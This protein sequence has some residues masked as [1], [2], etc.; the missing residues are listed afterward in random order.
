MGGGMRQAGFLAA[1]GLYALKHH[2][3]RLSVDHERAKLISEQLKQYN[4]VEE[5]MPVETNII[6]ARLKKEKDVNSLCAELTA[7]G[8]GISNIGNNSFR[9]VFH[10]NQQN[11]DIERLLE[12]LKEVK[13]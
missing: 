3:E 1:A 10:L 13:N 5:I 9:M 8:V 4:W 2:V 7:K 12:V 11:Q 6:I